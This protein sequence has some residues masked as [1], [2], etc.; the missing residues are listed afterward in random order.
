MFGWHDF[1]L[2]PVCL[3]VTRD[4][5]EVIPV[6][7]ESIGYGQGALRQYRFEPVGAINDKESIEFLFWKSE[8]EC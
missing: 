6:T 2:H 4:L 3:K 1:V 7:I 5:K 8:E